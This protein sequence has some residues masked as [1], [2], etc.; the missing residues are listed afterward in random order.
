MCFNGTSDSSA[1][2]SYIATQGVPTVEAGI[3]TGLPKNRSGVPY[4][5]VAGG[6]AIGN[7]FEGELPQVGNSFM[8][9]DSLSW[10]KG[11]HTMKFGADVRRERFDQTL[12]FETSGNFTFK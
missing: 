9:S 11:N 5:N 7:G 12:Y 4:I 6:F 2:N 10:V 1:I 8:W 3:T